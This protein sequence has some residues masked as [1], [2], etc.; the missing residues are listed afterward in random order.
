MISSS[1]PAS[2]LG[3]TK[4]SPDGR[5]A[6]SRRALETSMPTKGLTGASNFSL[7]SYYWLGLACPTLQVRARKGLRPRQLFGLRRKL[8]KG[9][10]DPGFHTASLKSQGEFG[11]SRPHRSIVD[12][13]QNTRESKYA[14]PTEI[15]VSFVRLISSVNEEESC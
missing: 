5:K 12:K 3:M 9:R 15:H 10:D 14:S 13:N 4:D 6:T 2:S 7:L 8:V 11:L 1:N